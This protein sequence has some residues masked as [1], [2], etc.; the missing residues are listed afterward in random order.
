MEMNTGSSGKADALNRYYFYTGEP[1]YFNQDLNRY[2]QIKPEDIS[3]VAKKYL[4]Q[5]KVTISIVPE[6]QKQIAL[7]N[8]NEIT[9]K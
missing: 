5:N 1:N 6:G 2:L 9:P 7:K 4:S 3:F 8:S